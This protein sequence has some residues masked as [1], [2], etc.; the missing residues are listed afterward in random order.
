MNA[1]VAIPNTHARQSHQLTKGTLPYFGANLGR[2][3]DDLQDDSESGTVKRFR[4]T[5]AATQ[6][7][8]S[9]K[10]RTAQQCYAFCCCFSGTHHQMAQATWTNA[11]NMAPEKRAHL[12]DALLVKMPETP[13]HWRS[14]SY[15]RLHALDGKRRSC[16]NSTVYHPSSSNVHE[17]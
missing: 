1:Q 3:R 16:S 11:T 8:A 4:T 15:C 5:P 7:T 13:E 17:F 6:S 9:E 10:M 14:G 2:Q 12:V